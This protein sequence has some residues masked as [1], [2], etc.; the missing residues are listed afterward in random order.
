M[1]K[2]RKSKVSRKRLTNTAAGRVLVSMDDEIAKQ[3]R[4]RLGVGK[5]TTKSTSRRR[6]ARGPKLGRM[7]EALIETAEEHRDQAQG[8]RLPWRGR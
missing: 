8:R 6:S 5:T 2:K 4:A 1:A 7:F 3:I